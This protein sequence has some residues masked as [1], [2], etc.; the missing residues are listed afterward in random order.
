MLINT[1]SPFKTLHT[2]KFY[3]IIIAVL[4]GLIQLYFR[5]TSFDLVLFQPQKLTYNQLQKNEKQPPRTPKIKK[6]TENIHALLKNISS[7]DT[8]NLTSIKKTH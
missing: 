2:H 5:I 4:L 7:T 3:F 1:T 8:I 6:S